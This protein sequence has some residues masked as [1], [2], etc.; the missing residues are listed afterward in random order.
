MRVADIDLTPLVKQLREDRV[1]LEVPNQTLEDHVAG[2]LNPGTGLVILERT[3]AHIPA[4]RD[5]A[6]DLSMATGLD[7]VIVR[8]PHVA[9]AVSDSLTRAQ[10]ERGERAM[11]AQPDYGDGVRAFLST[12]METQ[13][14][15]PAIAL[16]IAAVAA[17]VVVASWIATRRAFSS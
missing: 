13:P 12:S 9:I 15:W 10:V 11:V 3:P 8:T 14:A 4:V 1:A 6:Q 7:T 2:A 5:L 17:A 16:I